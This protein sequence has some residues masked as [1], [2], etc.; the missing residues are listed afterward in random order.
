L[1]SI[2]EIQ[3]ALRARVQQ[4]PKGAW[5]QGFK[6]DDTKTAE[7]RFF[8][9]SDLDAVSTEHPIYVAHRGGHVYFVIASLPRTCSHRT[10]QTSDLPLFV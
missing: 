4:T 10:T 3:A 9:R 2:G 6:F 8:T 7:N 5:V 1:R